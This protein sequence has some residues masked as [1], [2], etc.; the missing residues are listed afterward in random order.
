MHIECFIS[1]LVHGGICLDI[2]RNNICASVFTTL[3]SFHACAC[4]HNAGHGAW[5][6]VKVRRVEQLKATHILAA[7]LLIRWTGKL[8]PKLQRDTVTFST[9]MHRQRQWH[10]RTHT[11]AKKLKKKVNKCVRMFLLL[12]QQQQQ[13][14]QQRLPDQNELNGCCSFATCSQQDGD[15]SVRQL[16]RMRGCAYVP[17]SVRM[18]L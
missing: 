1:H 15:D 3:C 18:C 17:V 5:A 2:I 11:H 12:V 9:H 13:Q 14:H 16:C 7:I 6:K 8:K 4:M 10:V